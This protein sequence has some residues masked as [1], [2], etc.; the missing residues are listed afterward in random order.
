M[1]GGGAGLVEDLTG[2]RRTPAGRAAGDVFPGLP[3]TGIDQPQ[4]FIRRQEAGAGAAHHQAAGGYKLHGDPVEGGGAY[5]ARAVGANQ[6]EIAL[7][8][9]VEGS[10]PMAPM[11]EAMGKPLLPQFAGAFAN[12]LKTK[13]EA[14]YGS[15]AQ[16]KPERPS[17]I[18]AIVSEF[19]EM[20]AA[21]F[22]RKA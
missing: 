6:T 10:G 13:I 12:E 19:R 5:T 1:I 2:A 17:W 21:L 14:H 15:S 7:K 22:G 9:R 4:E 20:W 8:V 16:T 3:R 11:W 18:A